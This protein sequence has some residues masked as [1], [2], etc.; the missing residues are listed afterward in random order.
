[1]GDAAQLPV[2]TN[3]AAGAA[4][5][6]CLPSLAPLDPFFAE[7]RR[8]LR[9]TGTL[10]ALV[11]SGHRP[12]EPVTWPRSARAALAALV[13]ARDGHRGFRHRAACDRVGWLF[14]SADFAVLA[15]QR[16]VF[17]LEVGDRATAAS[18]VSG[19]VPAGV[20][21]PDVEP[22]RVRLAAA[23]LAEIAGP[24]VRLPLPLRLVLGRR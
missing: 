8:V 18:V 9:P 16:R 7:L 19:L 17:W 13:R 23:A 15:D 4:A 14:A 11:P 21:P 22:S 6:M 3:G 24:G 12:L 20:W 2:R 1:M 5:V 10:A